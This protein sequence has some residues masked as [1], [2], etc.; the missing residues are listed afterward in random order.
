M[1]AAGC[2]GDDCEL[3][4]NDSIQHDADVIGWIQILLTE[5]RSSP[6]HSLAVHYAVLSLHHLVVAEELD[7]EVVIKVLNNRSRRHS[8]APAGSFGSTHACAW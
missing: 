3:A 8:Q 2:R 4:K 6:M 1:M 7:F 5:E